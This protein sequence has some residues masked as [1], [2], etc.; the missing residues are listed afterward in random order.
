MVHPVYLVDFSVYKPPEEL[1][2]SYKEGHEPSKKWKIYDAEKDE[3]VTK[4]LS[5][6]GINME[7]T[8][9]PAWLNPQHTAEP[10]YDMDTALKEAQM[11]MCGAVSDLLEKTGLRPTDIDVLVTNSSI[12]CPTPSLCSLLVNHFK[13]RK[14]IESYH[15]GGMGCG[16]GVM[17]IGLLKNLLQ[18]RPNINAVFVPAEITTYCFYPGRHKDYMVANAIFRMG[19]AAIL[20]T[21][22]S[23]AARTA[24]YQLMQN[25][26]VHTGQDDESYG[27]MG[28]GP[29]ADG[30]NGVYLRK[31]IPAQAAKALD[32]CMRVVTPRIMTWSQYAEAAHTMFQKNVMG[33][34]VDPY[35]PDFTQCVDHFALHA[36]GYA[37]LKG[38]MKAMSLPVEKVLPSFSTLRDYG[39]TSCSTTWYVIA[40][41]ESV[42]GVK[43]GQTIMQIGMGGGMKAGVNI[44]RALNNNNKPHHAW[45]HVVGKPYTEADL[46]RPISDAREDARMAHVKKGDLVGAVN[47]AFAIPGDVA[48]EDLH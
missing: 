1:K 29:D 6:S 43:K 10:K 30:V 16:N 31:S 47:A 46:P 27:C 33:K 41:I 28:W 3:F 35:V 40:Y 2:L 12:F 14:D 44:W 37:V 26:R 13:M 23:N 7:G 4:I 19:G 38:L 39:N 36:G 20:L 25:V 45:A 21:N 32:H 42:L 15:L 5:K 8:Y 11:V 22:R 17:A 34:E 18:A 24:K 9:S 48:P